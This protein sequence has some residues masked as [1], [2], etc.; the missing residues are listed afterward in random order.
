MTADE[1]LE[2]Y[3]LSVYPP[4][5]CRDSID[6]LPYITVNPTTPLLA[7]RTQSLQIYGDHRLPVG[8]LNDEQFQQHTFSI[9]PR[10]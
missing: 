6:C 4:Y 8:N 9:Q 3:P 1:F 5:L 7:N 10:D 2:R